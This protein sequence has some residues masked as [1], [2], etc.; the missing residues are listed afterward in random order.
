MGWVVHGTNSSLGELS[1]GWNVHGV[2]CRWGELSIE[3]NVSGEN[4]CG[5]KCPWGEMSMGQNVTVWVLWGDLCMGLVATG[6]V[7]LAPSARLQQYHQ[8]GPY[9]R[10]NRWYGPCS[11]T[12]LVHMAAAEAGMTCGCYISLFSRGSLRFFMQERRSRQAVGS[13]DDPS[14]GRLVPEHVPGDNTSLWA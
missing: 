1:M 11:C 7:V 8:P 14:Q 12:G 3:S 5:A 4:V 6:R 2:K 10:C 13:R 9:C